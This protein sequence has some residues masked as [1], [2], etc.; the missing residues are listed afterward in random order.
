[1]G[2]GD[3]DEDVRATCGDDGDQMRYPS[4]DCGGG[5]Q[6]ALSSAVGGSAAGFVL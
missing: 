1:M 4:G 3:D 6:S 2:D 5:V